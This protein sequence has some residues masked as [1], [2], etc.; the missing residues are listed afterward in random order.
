MIESHLLILA[1]ILL[2]RAATAVSTG[3]VAKVRNNTRPSSAIAQ[4]T[5]F[6]AVLFLRPPG[7]KY[8]THVV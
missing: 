7:L 2:T 8:A 4:L 5:I 1:R 6:T 3:Y